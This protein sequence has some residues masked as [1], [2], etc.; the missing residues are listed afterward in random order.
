MNGR[1]FPVESIQPQ[2][3]QACGMFTGNGGASPLAST[4]TTPDIKSVTW[5][6]LGTFTVELKDTWPAVEAITGVLVD[7]T[8]D[9]NGICA[10]VSE[11]ISTNG[12]FVMQYRVNGAAANPDSTMKLGFIAYLRNRR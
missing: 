12:K 11:T 8:P 6:A 7:P 2:R 4:F 3:H 9:N 1:T 5:T 10:I